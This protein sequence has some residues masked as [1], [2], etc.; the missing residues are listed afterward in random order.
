MLIGGVKTPEQF[1]E[2]KKIREEAHKNEFPGGVQIVKEHTESFSSGRHFV[3]F[4]DNSEIIVWPDGR[5]SYNT[6]WDL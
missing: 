4:E 5:R 6:Y 3:W 2:V 1:R